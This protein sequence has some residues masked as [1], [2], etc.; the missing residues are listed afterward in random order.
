VC[1]DQDGD[2]RCQAEEPGIA[3][4]H[5]TLDPAAGQGLRV[6]GARTEITDADGWYRFS[7]VEPGSHVI[8]IVDPTGYWPPA[9]R[10]VNTAQ[11]ETAN[12]TVGFSVPAWRLSLPVTVRDARQGQVT[13]PARRI[14][15]PLIL[16][17][18]R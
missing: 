7:D 5:V 9:I 10:Q 13:P 12:I 15:L 1:Q 4:L 17:N 6:A 14:F 18:L 8:Q 11:H 16:R 3:G 2:G